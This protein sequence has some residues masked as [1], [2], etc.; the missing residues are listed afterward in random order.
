MTF[1][2]R[3][4]AAALCAASMIA[5][6]GCTMATSAPA[7]MVGPALEGTV[8]G[9]QQPV[10]GATVQLY[11]ATSTGY[12][13]AAT[14][15]LTVPVTTSL[16]GTFSIASDYTCPTG[17][18]VYLV[19]TG[20]NPG[21]V[22]VQ[23]NSG[24]AMM[25]GLGPCSGITG[26]KISVNELTT[27]ASVWALA[28]FMQSTSSVST[29][30][31][32]VQGLTNAFAAIN[33]LVSTS[34]GSLPGPALPA[35]ATIPA[36]LINTIADILA[37]CINTVNASTN[38]VSTNCN[39]LF[40]N[41][42]PSGGTAPTNT[43]Q[44]ALNM[45]K[46]PALN[47]TALSNLV[48]A[49]GAPFQPTVGGNAPNSWTLAINYAP[50]G[51]S[52]PKGITADSAGNI[53]IPNSGNNTV[54]ELSNTGAVLSGS[55]FGGGLLNSPSAI[56]IDT[57]GLAWVANT[58]NNTITHLASSGTTGTNYSGG[59]LNAPMGIA[60]DYAGDVWVSNSGSSTLSEFASTGA[61][62]SAASGYSGGGLNQPVAIAIGSN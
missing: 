44:A 58:G 40:T 29:S 2:F 34:A 56:A 57:N 4:T 51:M 52:T 6:T 13:A 16:T 42:T 21:I 41:T 9:G 36:P 55:G 24:L 7:T 54:T 49:T 25:A 12:G 38:T 18:M 10:S 17:G 39:T 23:N 27:V 31:T 22:S 43:I 62:I 11:A 28:P 15:L 32:N 45:A 3:L 46:N 35:N 48:P 14:S 26:T 50:A 33:K 53:W 37:A 47:L 1:S 20:G 8:R 5:M 60:I 30:S 59:G 19:V 61:A